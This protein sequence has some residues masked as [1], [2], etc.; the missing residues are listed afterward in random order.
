MKKSDF[1]L[2]I[3]KNSLNEVTTKGDLSDVESII[4]PLTSYT[5]PNTL[6]YH[7]SNVQPLLQS[8]G[9]VN[10]LMTY[11][12]GQDSSAVYKNTK[13]LKVKDLD[14]KGV[15]KGDL[16][17]GSKGGQGVVLYIDEIYVLVKLLSEDTPFEVLEAV[18]GLLITDVYSSKT[19]T[20]KFLKH[21]SDETEQG[22]NE[23]SLQFI[24]QKVEAKTKQIKSKV[25]IETVQDMFRIH[26]VNAKDILAN[27]MASQVRSEMDREVI[28]YI[29]TVAE[30]VSDLILK[31]SP[32]TKL[33]DIFSEIK[34]RIY[35]CLKE[36]AKGTN[37]PIKG[38]AIVSPTIAS[39]LMPELSFVNKN[40]DDEVYLGD[41]DTLKIFMDYGAEEDIVIVGYKS[42]QNDD[43]SLI[44][45]PYNQSVVTKTDEQ[46]DPLIYVYNRYTYVMNPQNEGFE[47]N[48]EFFKMF[49]VDFSC[50][51]NFSYVVGNKSGV[52][53]FCPE[54]YREYT[55][56]HTGSGTNTYDI[57][58]CNWSD[59]TVYVEGLF[60]TEGIDYFVENNQIV[61]T[62][63]P[64][65]DSSVKIKYTFLVVATEYHPTVERYVYD[66]VAE[67]Y[68]MEH[69]DIINLQVFVDG[70]FLNEGADYSLV[71]NTVTFMFQPRLYDNINFIYS[72][73]KE[74]C[75]PQTAY[76][77]YTQIEVYTGINTFKLEYQNIIKLTV[78]VEGLFM[79]E[80]VDYTYDSENFSVTF[81]EPLRPEA[82]VN[83][84]Y[85]FS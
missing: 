49:Y 23:V 52:G 58:H 37:R 26:G 2:I 9:S 83:F 63:T 16:I 20:N 71:Q 8:T 61:F 7:I 4:A 73:H 40:E 74:F 69:E 10:S 42:E 66:G 54:N 55:Q 46:G 45:A 3:E 29:K 27:M 76:M 12:N 39:V 60:M 59:L 6:L 1:T 34:Y 33:V 24:Q 84:H 62:E 51:K 35:S 50:I 57:E 5:Y 68:T 31:E 72:Y 81:V 85:Y 47:N 65:I 38:Y 82:N 43:A 18:K 11:Y 64:P 80:G 41:I 13:V 32:N 17:Q 77:P 28:D 25:T 21:Y 56:Y 53:I 14:K 75:M 67:S 44:F 30:P 79:T 15:K 78:Y 22:L 19:F 48:S 70:L 36:I